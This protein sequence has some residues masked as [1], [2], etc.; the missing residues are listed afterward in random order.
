VDAR[1]IIRRRDGAKRAR[2]KLG[3]L[4]VS[5]LQPQRA[6]EVFQ[7]DHTLVD[8]IVVDREN[9]RPIGRP[10]LILAVDIKTRMIAGFHVSLWPLSALSV[11]WLSLTR[12]YLRHPGLRTAN[13]R[14]SIGLPQVY[15]RFSMS[16]M[17]ESFTPR[18]W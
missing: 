10:W 6:L 15:R 13:S 4:S 12:F 2:E 14:R 11:V 8:V 18:R 7:I 16:T 1:T 3:P 17:P 9:R 5:S